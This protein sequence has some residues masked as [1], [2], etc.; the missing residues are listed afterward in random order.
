[1]RIYLDN[2]YRFGVMLDWEGYRPE[3]FKEMWDKRIACYTYKKYADDTW[4]ESEFFETEVTLPSG[5]VVTMKLAERGVYYKREK[6]WVRE[7]RKL[8]ESKHQT[9]LI[10]TDFVNEA[11]VVAGKMFARWSQENF[12][13]YMM[14]HFGID[15]LIEYKQEEIDE[16]AEV[17][18][19]TETI[20]PGINLRLVYGLVSSQIPAVQ[21]F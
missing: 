3:F 4:P 1:M 18:N 5:E 2:L 16:T 21:E 9:T 13:K 8:S 14:E 7:I 15:R 6:L 10:T 11:K 12:L 20:F 17:L 19:S